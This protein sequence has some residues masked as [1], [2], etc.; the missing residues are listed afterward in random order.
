MQM[1]LMFAWVALMAGS[2]PSRVHHINIQHMMFEPAAVSVRKGDV[3]EW[4]NAD[5]VA[6]TATSKQK[7]F[8]TGSLERGQSKRVV[9]SK[10]GTFPYSCRFH[11]TM[12]GTVI[13]R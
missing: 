5:I 12:S 10:R 7:A 13:V 2:G 11:L 4:R 8:D 9:V 6:H 3:I 1:S